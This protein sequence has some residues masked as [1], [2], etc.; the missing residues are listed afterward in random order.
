MRTELFILLLTVGLGFIQLFLASAAA[1]KVRGQKYNFSSRDEELPPLKGKPAHL[2]RAFKN[3]KET[4][5]FFLASIFLVISA[6]K[7]GLISAIS[8]VVY[9][10]ARIIYVFLYVYDVIYV[11]SA[12]WLLS[13]AGIFGILLQTFI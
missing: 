5:P 3:F 2:D 4:F 6:D 12:I 1:T 9:L 8:A 10:V 7:T 13:V 11:R